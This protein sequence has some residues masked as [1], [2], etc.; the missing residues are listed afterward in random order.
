MRTGRGHDRRRHDLLQLVYAKAYGLAE[1]WV[2]LEAERLLGVG[3]P[4]QFQAT[5]DDNDGEPPSA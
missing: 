2:A 5:L 1:R 3:R 4:C